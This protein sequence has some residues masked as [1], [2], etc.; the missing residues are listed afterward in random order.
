MPASITPVGPGSATPTSGPPPGAGVPPSPGRP[1]VEELA[2]RPVEA[3]GGLPA[4]LGLHVRAHDDSPSP[5]PWP[6]GPRPG[7]ATNF[8]NFRA[9]DISSMVSWMTLFLPIHGWT[10]GSASVFTIKARTNGL[11]ALAERVGL[12]RVA[13]AS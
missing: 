8:W 13:S 6:A 5:A 9:F 3:A 2:G 1:E 10:R 4:D 11:V 12:H 7:R